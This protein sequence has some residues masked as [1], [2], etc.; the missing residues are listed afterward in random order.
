[1]YAQNRPDCENII[2]M[3]IESSLSAFARY[4]EPSIHRCS[5]VGS[6]EVK[7]PEEFEGPDGY[8][9]KMQRAVTA[10]ATKSFRLAARVIQCRKQ[11]FS[12][13]I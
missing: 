13:Y 9:D 5:R 12:N 10:F 6:M 2:D 11:V 3:L 4:P 1:M 8:L 7:T